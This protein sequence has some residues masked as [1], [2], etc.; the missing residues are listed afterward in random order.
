MIQF[1][2][3]EGNIGDFDITTKQHVVSKSVS[4]MVILTT[5][6]MV[7]VKDTHPTYL[8]LG[9]ITQNLEIM[10]IEAGKELRRKN[11]G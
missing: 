5:E 6:D 7:V 4:Y 2:T 10:G 11:N 1:L 9:M 3:L 8:M